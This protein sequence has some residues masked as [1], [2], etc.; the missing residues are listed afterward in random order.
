[1]SPWLLLGAAGLGAY[2]LVSK[3]SSSS[4]SSSAIQ[5]PTQAQIDAGLAPANASGIAYGSLTQNPSSGSSSLPVVQT[6]MPGTSA[7][8]SGLVGY[9]YG[10]ARF[11]FPRHMVRGW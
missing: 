10:R 6:P 4:G 5:N 9:S 1:M 2:Y 7:T 3:S 11:G 8:S